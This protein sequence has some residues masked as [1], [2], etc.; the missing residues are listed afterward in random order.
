M[1]QQQLP[2][3]PVVWCEGLHDEQYET[4][5]R[6]LFSVKLVTTLTNLTETTGAEAAR[7]TLFIMPS[8]APHS[9]DRFGSTVELLFSYVT[10]SGGLSHSV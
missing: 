6:P 1:T 4:C 5:C 10:I 7:F 3:L 9:K 2:K 8:F